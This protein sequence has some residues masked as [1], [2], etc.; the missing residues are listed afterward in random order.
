VA[1]APS[2][3]RRFRC[4]CESPL[5]C[6]SRRNLSAATDGPCTAQWVQR[7][8]QVTDVSC[9][10]RHVQGSTRGAYSY[11]MCRCNTFYFFSVLYGQGPDPAK[12]YRQQ[13]HISLP[14]Y[15]L[16]ACLGASGMKGIDRTIIPCYLKLNSGGLYALQS[17]LLPL[18]PNKP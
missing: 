18:L 1:V 12:K 15:N 3:L 17:T 9:L 5:K 16:R 11:L 4:E 14:I 10:C 2:E 7:K 6:R 13:V 8:K